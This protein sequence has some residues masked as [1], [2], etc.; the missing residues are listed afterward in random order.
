M[1]I[2]NGRPVLHEVFLYHPRKELKST[3]YSGNHTVLKT[4]SGQQLVLNSTSNYTFS[5]PSVSA[6]DIGLEYTFVNINTGRL[7]IDPA[8]DDTIDAS[9]ATTGTLYSDTDSIASITIRLVSATH[10]QIVGANG[11]WTAT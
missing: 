11:T 8:D 2:R 6:A 7:T 5:L 1:E 3:S 4:Q 9:T 10:W